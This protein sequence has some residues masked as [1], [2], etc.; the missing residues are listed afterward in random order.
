MSMKIYLPALAAIV[1]MLSIITAIMVHRHDRRADERKNIR[2]SETQAE[3]TDCISLAK[4]GE[5]TLVC[6][7]FFAKH[8]GLEP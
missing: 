1:I 8:P 2:H 3:A 6:K 7:S 4:D 5:K